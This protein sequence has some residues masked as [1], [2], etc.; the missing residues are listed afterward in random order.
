MNSVRL[1]T[2]GLFVP[3]LLAAQTSGLRITVVAGEGAEH[4]AG[5]RVSKP[6]TIQVSDEAGRPVADSRVS[7]QLP[8]D[9]PSGVF[10]NG[11]RTE[12][13][14]TDALGRA[15]VRTFQ[16]NQIAG[17][18]SLRITVAKDGA[19]AGVIVR[20]YVIIPGGKSAQASAP[21]QTEQAPPAPEHVSAPENGPA[22]DRVPAADPAKPTS[23]TVSVSAIEKQ[24]P[25]EAEGRNRPVAARLQGT[26]D[27]PDASVKRRQPV[28]EVTITRR[29]SGLSSAPVARVSRSHKKWVL[30][31]ILA[32][33]GAGGAFAGRTMVSGAGSGVAAAAASTVASSSAS[34]S[35]GAPTINVGHP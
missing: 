31:A 28:S 5:S 14:I 16:L 10:A 25:L 22:A 13:A 17:A 6:L 15:S 9:G 12:L 19:R 34:V 2:L 26:T 20:Q 27:A 29:N 23:R 1:R 35:I 32:A 18:L 21:R 24:H 8:G 33:G 7:F 4:V 3:V 30:L 11:L